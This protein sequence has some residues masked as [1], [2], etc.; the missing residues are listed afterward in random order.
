MTEQYSSRTSHRNSLLKPLLRLMFICVLP[1]LAIAQTESSVVGF[2]NLPPKDFPI[3]SDGLPWYSA[4]Q[5]MEE[6]NL[7]KAYEVV[8]T[9][10]EYSP[11]TKAERRRIK[12]LKLQVP[13]SITIA[14]SIGISRKKAILDYSFSPIVKKNGDLLRLTSVKISIRHIT[15]DGKGISLK[16]LQPKANALKASASRW[17]NESVLSTGKW[18]K[19]RVGDEGIYALTPEWLARAGFSH[20]DRV[21]LYGYGGRILAEDWTFEGDEC[22]PDDLT[23]IPL[24]RGASGKLLFFAEGTVRTTWYAQ[25][26]KWLH[27][28]N[29]Y[30]LHS[31]YFLTEGDQPL[32]FEVY[33]PQIA[34]PQTVV[35]TVPY[36]TVMDND[37][38][39][40]Y[41]GGREMY[42][43]HDFAYGNQKTYKITTPSASTNEAT[44]DVAMSAAST[45]STT[46]A[47]ISINGEKLGALTINK[48]GES[49]SGYES[50]RSYATDNLSSTQNSVTIA[51][52]SSNPARLNFIRVNYT[53]TLNA[54]DA[55]FAFMPTP[56]GK[57]PIRLQAEQ[58]HAGTQLWQIQTA[59]QTARAIAVNVENGLLTADIEQPSQ[60]Y[61]LVDTQRDYPIPEIAEAEVPNQNLHADSL[62]DMVIIIPKSRRLAEEA[63]RL[64]E[65]HRQQQGLRVKLVDAGQIYNEFSSGTPDASAYR[66]YLKMLYDRAQ[67][68]TDLPRYLLLFGDCVWD[69]R[70]L[71]DQ[72]K[73]ASPDDYLLAF[74]VSDGFNNPS[75]TS[76]PIGEISSYV[77]DDFYG[78]LD[79]SEGS[80]YSKNKLDISIGRFPCHDETTART[81]VD[82]SIAYLSNRQT[83]SWKNTVYM[84][85]DYGNENLHMNDATPV[86]A[87][88]EESTGHRMEVKRIFWD[89]YERVTSGTG[90][91]FP[92]VTTMVQKAMREGALV[93]NYTGHGSPEQISHARI[94]TT[95]DFETPAQGNL[96]LWVMAS[97]EISP[98]DSDEHDIGRA[99]LHNP[100]GGAVAVVCA[101]RAV[102]SNYNKELN[103]LLNKHLFSTTSDATRASF[104]EALSRT[105]VELLG[106]ATSSMK[107]GSINKLKYALLGDPALSLQAPTA[108]VV[109]DSINGVN[110]AEQE[111]FTLAAES[112]VRFSG[113]IEYADASAA[114]D[115][116][117]V[118]N[119]LLKD[120]RETITCHNYNNTKV[121]PFVYSEHTKTIFEGTDS[122]HNGQ[123]SITMRIPRS[124]S[125]SNDLAGI[126]FYASDSSM[127]VEANGYASKF[128]LNGTAPNA[129]PDTIAP[130]VYLYI[131]TPEFPNGGIVAT[132]ATLLARIDDNVGI[133]ATDISI[134]Q[135][136]ALTIDQQH[137]SPIA[138]HP[139]FTYDFGSYQSGT[140]SYPLSQ[141]NPG[142]HTLQLKVWD[143]SGNAT[144]SHLD[145]YVSSEKV[146]QFNVHTTQNPATT[147]T[148]LVCTF[149]M[150]ND[151]DQPTNGEVTF[152]IFDTTGRRIWQST[153][154]SNTFGAS[155]VVVPWNLTSSAG[156]RVSPGIY[157]YQATL[158]TEKGTQTTDAKKIIVITQ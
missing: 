73:Y 129:A 7:D 11:L 112:V 36:Y 21:K 122:V 150:N 71:T 46:T 95:A 154:Q 78:W 158:R 123:F 116:N 115:F 133:N 42:D 27:Q 92:T 56:Q 4:Q 79:D 26:R 143:I 59:T 31:Y 155:S 29:P 19:I 61:I 135:N 87:Q 111:R 96:P 83:G 41:Q 68:D 110:V 93:F 6:A 39:G 3:T 134:G 128:C 142:P 60:R 32:P 127:G 62:I 35:H 100:T 63:E 117:G 102:Y 84:L 2:V 12:Q 124:I 66:R 77:T 125:Y 30:A 147:R 24:Y 90:H 18:V 52:G 97:C 81:M 37:A 67:N 126:Y 8:L 103:I 33:T 49:Q 86:I 16:A 145:F 44:I 85:A 132:N 153:A 108:Q 148:Q 130:N 45:T 137:T 70:M 101:S 131:N 88:I 105:K 113:H 20:P 89:A 104:G 107:D 5:Q 146:D 156:A 53:R 9:Y 119:G 48:Y 74:E 50:R 94:V 17:K 1:Q 152:S 98:F 15:N 65:A 144:T 141:L 43:T 23:E 99:A 118:I 14:S 157:L 54:A 136:M 82:K 140:L 75:N 58:A 40:W 34:Q 76:F 138:M 114:T 121:D 91:T 72:W 10:P 51:T 38:F 80:N 139:Y 64:A 120:R 149:P 109:L 13:D 151:G 25:Q 69:N 57:E 28:N 47:T 106:T 22:V 55:P